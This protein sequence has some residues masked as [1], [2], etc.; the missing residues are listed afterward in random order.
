MI[1]L[2]DNP[3]PGY[4]IELEA[5]KHSNKTSLEFEELLY[6]VKGMCVSFSG[7]LTSIKYLTQMKD[8]V[9]VMQRKNEK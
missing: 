9:K 6:V 5:R 1:G 7:L 2:G 4:S 3:S 8:V